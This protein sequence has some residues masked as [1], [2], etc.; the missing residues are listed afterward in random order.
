MAINPEQWFFEECVEEGSAFGLKI[1]QRVHDEQTPFQ[2]VEIFE[3]EIW[4]NLMVNDGYV[5]LSS[6]DN[7]FYHEMMAH[8]ALFSH[9]NPENVVVIGGG[10]CGTLKEVLHH[11]E[12]KSATQVEIDKVVTDLAE[13]Y[14][15]ELCEKNND[16]RATL[17]FG[18]GI[19]W[20]EEQAAES[21]DVIIVDSTDPV[22][23]AEGLFNQ[24]FFDNCYRVLKQG[25]I[26]I[27]QSGSPFLHKT[28]MIEPMVE[29]MRKA[30]FI[31]PVTVNFPQ[32]VYPSG[33]WSGTMARKGA[34]FSQ[35]REE[36]VKS[37]Q[38]TTKYYNEHIHQACLAKPNLLD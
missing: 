3:T 16:P 13:K 34:D 2:R 33:Y 11:P 32:P 22:G 6:R 36:A 14:F 30:D 21:V 35:F 9:S 23:P 20:M 38:F 37:K 12:V 5:M 29:K 15:P 10:D 24:P 27:Q 25:G 28:T 17:F 26:L 18:D 8:P 4:G 7:F 19:K 31:N 1:K